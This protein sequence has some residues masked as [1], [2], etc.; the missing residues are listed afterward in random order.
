[1]GQNRKI[2]DNSHLITYKQNSAC[3]TW[4]KLISNSQRL[5]GERFRVLKIGGLNKRSLPNFEIAKEKVNKNW[6]QHICALVH[7]RTVFYGP[8]IVESAATV[9]KLHMII[10]QPR[11]IWRPYG[12]KHL[13]NKC[14]IVWLAMR[15][16][17][18]VRVFG[19]VP[20]E[21]ASLWT[22][23]IVA[24][25]FVFEPW[26]PYLCKVSWSFRAP[27]HIDSRARAMFVR[28]LSLSS[29][30]SKFMCGINVMG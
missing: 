23:I 8:E 12:S 11:A 25:S 16:S 6:T 17:K 19:P 4:P 28:C 7:T 1:M 10:S 18:V 29:S 30:R 24:C 14:G 3:L 21:S 5:D 20:Y 13:R 26:L 27:L 9:W 2:P 15:L 22:Q